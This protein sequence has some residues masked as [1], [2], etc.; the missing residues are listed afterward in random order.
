MATCNNAAATTSQVSKYYF[1]FCGYL[2]TQ[3]PSPETRHSGG[4]QNGTENTQYDSGK[5]NIFNQVKNCSP[6]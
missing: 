5:I 4:I 6:V 3:A 1:W 2:A